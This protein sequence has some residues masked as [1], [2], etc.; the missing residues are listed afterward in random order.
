MPTEISHEN[1]SEALD[2]FDSD[3]FLIAL[4]LDRIFSPLDNDDFNA[5]E[6]DW[7]MQ[8]SSDAEGDED[9]VL[10]DKDESDADNEESVPSFEEDE[11]D[12]PITF[13]LQKDALDSLQLGG[14]DV[15]WM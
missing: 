10:F 6:E 15:F 13:D 9:S 2:D 14:W 11:P 7:L 12:E 5:G 3:S 1:V 8:L 4:C